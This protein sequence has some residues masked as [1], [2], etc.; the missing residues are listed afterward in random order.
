MSS[1]SLKT[2]HRLL[3]NIRAHLPRGLL[4]VVFG[5]GFH[6]VDKWVYWVMFLLYKPESG[7]QPGNEDPAHS[8]L[9]CALAIDDQ[10]SGWWLGL[11][12][13]YS[14]KLRLHSCSEVES[15]LASTKGPNDCLSD[16]NDFLEQIE[17]G[18]SIMETLFPWRSRKA[19]TIGSISW[20]I[21]KKIITLSLFLSLILQICWEILSAQTPSFFRCGLWWRRKNFSSVHTILDDVW[22]LLKNTLAKFPPF[23]FLSVCQWFEV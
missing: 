15:H 3:P 1:F 9:G 12:I 7:Q 8:D 14:R 2:G 19:W 6:A 23:W 20:T 5:E 16:A 18:N 10:F 22:W 17:L 4:T 13:Y 21:A 11:Q